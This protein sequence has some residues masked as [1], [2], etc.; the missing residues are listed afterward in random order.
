MVSIKTDNLNFED[1]KIL[2]S[3]LLF[4]K[5]QG[6]IEY[7]SLCNEIEVRFLNDYLKGFIFKSGTWLAVKDSVFICISCKD[8]EKYD[9][10]ALNEL[11]VYSKR[12][13]GNSVKKILV[14]TKEPCK[15]CVI[16]RA[17]AMNINLIILDKDINRFRKSIRSVI[18]DN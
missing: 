17:K 10:D 8:S 2:N 11:E 18:L 5:Q 15:Q 3:C 14:A 4:L 6:G 12:L 1:R 9:E 7:S 16:E 13:G